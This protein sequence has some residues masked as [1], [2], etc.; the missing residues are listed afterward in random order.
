[1]NSEAK[2]LGRV[3]YRRSMG[4][5]VGILGSLIVCLCSLSGCFRSYV[6]VTSQ[7]SGAEIIRDGARTGERTPA[8]FEPFSGTLTVEMEGYETP[9]P[10]SVRQ[11][12]AVGRIVT[13]V[14]IWPLGGILWGF[15][16]VKAEQPGYHFELTPKK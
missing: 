14:F 15:Q 4:R 8:T 11:R 7:P 1:M 9:R 6:D 5:S 3:E 13:T 10:Y 12:V 2:Y 16:F